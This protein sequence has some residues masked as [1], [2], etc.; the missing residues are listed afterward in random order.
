M[1]PLR[2]RL[3]AILL[4]LA[5]LPVI[6]SCSGGG[7][8]SLSRLDEEER[9]YALYDILAQSLESAR[10]VAVFSEMEVNARL[11]GHGLRIT[12]TETQISRD[13]N[14]RE[15]MDH[16]ESC[17]R[18][19]HGGDHGMQTEYSTASGYADGYIYRSYN[20]DGAKIAA[21]TAVPYD[22]YVNEYLGMVEQL[23]LTPD[24]WECSTVTCQRTEDG[25]FTATFGGINGVGLGDIAYGYG[26]DLS[27]LGDNIYLTDATV[28]VRSTPALLFDS[29]DFLLTYTLFDEEGNP[30]DRTYA[31]NTHQTY[32]YEIPDSFRGV[33]LSE[34]ED[35]GDLTVLDDY[36]LYLDNRVYAPSGYYNY[37]S[38]ETVTE[39]GAASVWRYDVEMEFDTFGEGITYESKGNYGFEDELYRTRNQYEDGVIT[40]SETNTVT[41]EAWS[42]SYA[43]TETDLRD[44]ILSEIEVRDFYAA[45]VIRIEET[46][47]RAGK[48]R[49]YLGGGLEQDYKEYFAARKGSL[50]S[51]TAYLDVVLSEGK[52][53][54]YDFCLVAEGTTETAAH[55]RYELTA[56][57]T[58][59]EKNTNSVPL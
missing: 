11:D 21:K 30:T 39:D 17:Y 44:L 3:L 8:G 47:A 29:V 12:Y 1:K 41:G 55:H 46:D 42:D 48:Y 5:M 9:A 15:R 2:K 25:S 37:T 13:Q 35:I 26:A 16:Y 34:Y 57:C 53:I 18:V 10:S 43:A 27:M 40:F 58:F 36:L 33:D 20:D 50:K 23:L 59:A 38:R 31:V 14:R 45:Y 54:A 51:L 4:L 28:E 49:L 32:A 24:A 19:Q 6:P 52:L 56:C 7:A 22:E